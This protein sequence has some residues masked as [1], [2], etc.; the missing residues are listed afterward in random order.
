[1]SNEVFDFDS[2]STY[3][4]RVRSTDS[5]GDI[6]EESFAINVLDMDIKYLYLPMVG[7]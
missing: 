5:N 1:L 3:S 7:K 2:R 6:Y 4:I